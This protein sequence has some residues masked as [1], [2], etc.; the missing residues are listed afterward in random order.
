MPRSTSPAPCAQIV[1]VKLRP[2][3]LWIC[4]LAALALS[5]ARVVAQDSSVKK[6]DPW[7]SVRFLLGRWEGG[8]EGQPGTGRS[9]REYAFTLNNRFIEVHNRSVY[10]PQE[11]NPKGEQHEDRGMMSYD[12]AVKKLV[13]RQFHTE[14]FVNHYVLD[15]VSDDG[16][17]VVFVSASIEN[18]PTGFRA[19]ETYT[20]TGEDTFTEVFELAEPGK[21]FEKYSEAHF[22]RIKS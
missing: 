7:E 14:G 2:F 3:L 21:D 13:L 18:I 5:T 11:K 10:P 16:R 19:R 22:V 1:I 6:P 12:R 8:S 17:T 4:S 15:S 9:S 20:R